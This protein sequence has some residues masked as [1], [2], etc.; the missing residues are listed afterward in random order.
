[1]ASFDYK[2]IFEEESWTKVFTNAEGKDE[3]FYSGIIKAFED[4]EY[5]NL[6]ISTEEVDCSTSWFGSDK[7]KMVCVSAKESSL[8]MYRVFF[9]ANIIGN[10]GQFSRYECMQR[11]FFDKLGAVTGTDKRDQLR[12]SCTS[13][14]DWETFIMLDNLANIVYRQIM[15]KIDPDYESSKRLLNFK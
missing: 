8:S 5:P 9:S 1:M 11:G 13:L 4:S 15:V 10:T 6:D 14:T 3:E 2:S 12:I 7:R